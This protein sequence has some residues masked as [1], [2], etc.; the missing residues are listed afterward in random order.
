[1]VPGNTHYIS[2]K[3]DPY[4][5]LVYLAKDLGASGVDLDYEEMWHAD[6]YKTGPSGGPWQLTQ[7]VYKYAAIAEDIIINIQN[8]QPSLLFST[9]AGAAGAWSGSWWGGNLKGVWLYTNQWFPD[10]ISFMTKTSGV[11]VMTYDLSDNEQYYECPTTSC[12]TLDCQVQF[13]MS[14]FTQAGIDAN[15]GYEVGTPAYPNPTE[16]PSHQLPLTTAEL[17]TITTST[18]PTFAGGF[19]WELYKDADGDATP[20][21]VAQSICNVVLPGNSRC[22]GTIPIVS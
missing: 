11:N 3:R 14:T 17:Q 13:Y 10:V 20:T 18:Q 5:D 1:M 7:T 12:C 4:Q 6:Y 19:M 22:K 9:A 2:A 8:I 16:D 21:Q 15:V